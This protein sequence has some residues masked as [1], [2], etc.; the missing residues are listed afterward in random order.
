MNKLA[1]RTLKLKFKAGR[2]PTNNQNGCFNEE[3]GLKYL[4]HLHKKWSKGPK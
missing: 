1:K 2:C 3:I 4:K